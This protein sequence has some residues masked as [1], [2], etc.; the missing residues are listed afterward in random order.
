M[1]RIITGAIALLYAFVVFGQ[2]QSDTIRVYFEANHDEFNPNL[3][4]NAS[5]MERFIE[6]VD[7]AKTYDAIGS[8]EVYGYASPAGSQAH[9]KRL[10]ERRCRNIANY[11]IMHTGIDS[12][13]VTSK[14]MGEA[15]DELRVMVEATPEV[16][17]R[18]KVLDIIANT[19]E[20]IFDSRSRIIDGRKKRLMDLA[21]GRPYRWLLA[22]IFPKLHCTLSISVHYLTIEELKVEGAKEATV[23]IETISI[24]EPIEIDE[25]ALSAAPAF[26]AEAFPTALIGTSDPLHRLAIKTNLAYDAILLPSLEL[27]WLASN[28]WSVALEGSV[29][30][31]GKY[32]KDR[33]YRLAIISPEV[34]YWIHPHAPWHGFY[35]GAF[36]GGGLYDL[37][38]GT[39]G[40][41][42]E[43]VMGGLS[44]GYMWPLSRRLSFEAAVGAGYLFT[45]YKEYRPMDG[46]HVYQ[47][48]KELQYY[49]PLKLKFSLV[50][51]LWDTNKPTRNIAEIQGI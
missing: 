10:S 49:G 41:R 40:Y 18:D 31:W 33:S 16:P 5:V 27:E 28:H 45:H 22:N 8:I 46:H 17:Y 34:K 36:A 15:W 50:W 25:L 3:F 42:G 51:R 6:K 30:W 11:I 24:V 1:I 38:K 4:D 20:W 48:T 12:T 39:S 43:G 7:N 47:R 19:P 32:S 35:V 9:N 14:G 23:P 21:G 2:T 29:A 13:L 37:L 44:L 26:S